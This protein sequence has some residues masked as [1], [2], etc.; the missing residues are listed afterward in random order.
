LSLTIRCEFV[1]AEERREAESFRRF[2]EQEKTKSRTRTAD[3]AD[4]DN[5][6]DDDDVTM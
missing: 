3:T 6:V 4:N 2:L 5:D 1:D